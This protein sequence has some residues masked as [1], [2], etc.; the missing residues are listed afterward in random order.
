[1][2]KR[3]GTASAFDSTLRAKDGQDIPVLISASVLVDEAGHEIGTVGFATDVR[4]RRR[5]EEELAKA[6]DELEQRVEERTV[7]LKAARGGMRYLMSVAPGIMYT[8][9]ASG[10]FK[11]TFVSDNVDPIM[12]FSAWEMLEDPKFWSSRL[13]PEDAPQV[14]AE[15]GRLIAAGGGTVEYRFR[16]RD[17]NTCGSR[18]RSR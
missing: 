13:H 8:N 12:G 1:M 14:F 3:G 16:H 5:A 17:G 7:E 15:V 18:T 2:R 10:A 6:H 11:C 9:Q 4:E